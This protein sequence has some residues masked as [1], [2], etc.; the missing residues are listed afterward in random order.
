MTH[1]W[2]QGLREGWGRAGCRTGHRY[3]LH[4]S[5][6]QMISVR[7]L[8]RFSLVCYPRKKQHTWKNTVLARPDTCI[9]FLVAPSRGPHITPL[10]SRLDTKKSTDTLYTEAERAGTRASARALLLSVAHSLSGSRG[11]TQNGISE[12][13]DGGLELLDWFADIHVRVDRGYRG[14]KSDD[15]G[16]PIDIPPRKP[17]KS[18]KHPQPSMER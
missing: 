6:L 13:A 15:C 18:H 10:I 9:I 7:P 12:S 17:R 14:I 2:L 1:D 11:S 5:G 8:S 3:H 16:E 4:L